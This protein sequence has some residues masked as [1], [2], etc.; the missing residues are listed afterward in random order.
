[1][2]QDGELLFQSIRI[3][4]SDRIRG[5]FVRLPSAIVQVLENTSIPVHE[6]GIAIQREESE[7]YVGWDGFESSQALNGQGCVEINPILAAAYNVREGNAVDLK[8]RHFDGSLIATEVYIEPQSSDDWE[9]IDGNARFLQNEM[10]FQTRIVVQDELLICY[11]E[12]TVAKFKIQKIIPQFQGAARITTDTLVMVAPMLNRSRL[13]NGTPKRHEEAF[14]VHKARLLRTT[15]HTERLEG[16]TM[17][18]SDAISSLALVSIL[19]NPIENKVADNHSAD[20]SLTSCAERIAVAVVSDDTVS[21]THAALSSLTWASLGVSP[22]SGHKLKVEYVDGQASDEAPT[23]FI[24]PVDQSKNETKLAL[25]GR[26]ASLQ[27]SVMQSLNMLMIG[28][29]LTDRLYLPQAQAYIELVSQNGEHVQFYDWRNNDIEYRP[30]DTSVKL[31]RKA[32]TKPAEDIV[33]PVGMK[34]MIDKIIHYLTL[35]FTSS[36]IS[37]ITGSSGMGK[38]ILVK[39]IKAQIEQSTSVNVKYIDCEK[40]MENSNFTKMKQTLQQ[41]IASSY[42]YGPSLLILDNAEILFPQNKSEDESQSRSSVADVSTKLCQVLIQYLSRLS[43]KSSDRVRLLLTAE[44]RDK[45]NQ[46]LFSKHAIGNYWQLQAPQRDQRCDLIAHFLR[47]RSLVLSGELDDSTIAI[48]TEGHSPQDL[49]L[50]TEK[51]LCENL[52]D[53]DNLSAPLTRETFERAVADFTPSSLRGIKLQKDTGVRWSSVGAMHKAKELLLETLEWPTKYAPIFAKCPLRLRSG[54]LLYGYPGCGKTMLASAVAQ[55]CGLNFISIKGPEIL[56]KYIGA[57]EQ[58]VREC[59]ERAQ[60]ARP[61]ILFFDEFDSVAPKRGHDSIGVTDRVVNQMLTQMDGAEGLEG[62]YVLAA[63]SRPDLIDSALLRPGRLDKSVLCGLPTTPDR[64]EILKA[65]VTSGNMSLDSDCNLEELAET[66]EGMSGADLQGLCYNAYLKSVHRKMA[67]GA[68]DMDPKETKGDP[69]DFE[70]FHAMPPN[71]S[72][73]SQK[74][75]ARVKERYASK[76]DLVASKEIE[77]VPPIITRGDFQ[78]ACHDTKPSISPGEFQKLTQIYR[79]F[80]SDRDANMPSGEAS[81][82]VGGRLTL[83]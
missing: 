23:V 3:S 70:Y 66:T 6:Y 81:N 28:T 44:T 78:K 43:A 56:N 58:S 74:F 71:S 75:L 54:I 11:V 68:V 45:M 69:V 39:E 1:M 46:V 40:F 67:S 57:S 41:L 38:T 73:A 31:S 16:F 36:S 13:V 48:E 72:T 24:Y 18:V 34:E 63:T 10:L 2:V 79:L 76:D 42:W 27:D 9:I 33:H 62:V 49:L 26:R 59:F 82:Q 61:C 53:Q 51:L 50:L 37:L 29:V 35:P 30:M 8:I 65:V 20:A 77:V 64:L 12:Q 5:N 47:Q 83:M 21:S 22:E 15:G 52:C 7:I 14:S 32:F 19:K 17:G 4:F 55:H 25:N 80:S 60:A